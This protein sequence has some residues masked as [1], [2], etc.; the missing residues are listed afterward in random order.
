M[1][2]NSL[3]SNFDS[4][5]KQFSKE[6]EDQWALISN[7]KIVIHHKEFKVVFDKANKTGIAKRAIFHKIPKKELIIV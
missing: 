5:P 7:G 1:S 2:L 3:N 6:L 4:I